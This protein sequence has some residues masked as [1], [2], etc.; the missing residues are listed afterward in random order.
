[1]YIQLAKFA[2]AELSF[3]PVPLCD[4]FS[5]DWMNGNPINSDNYDPIDYL[6]TWCDVERALSVN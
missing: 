1:M 2:I 5:A 3:G 6:D 4:G